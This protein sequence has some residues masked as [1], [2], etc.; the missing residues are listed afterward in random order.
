MNNS[1]PEKSK[2]KSG[3]SILSHDMHVVGK[4]F[5]TGD[6]QIEGRLDGDLRSHA[7][8]IGEKA[9][10]SGEV[11]G[12]MVTVFGQVKGTIRARQVY[13]CATSKVTG[14]VFNEVLAIETGAQ[15]NGAVNREKDPLKNAAIKIV[16]EEEEKE[17]SK[18]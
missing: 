7:V 11:A 10:V 16:A 8:T 17:A 3:P 1:M 14:D 2:P 13:L 9:L 12:D 18:A 15:L 4:I 6:I 5:S